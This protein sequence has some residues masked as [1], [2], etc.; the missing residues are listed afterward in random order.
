MSIQ[1]TLIPIINPIRSDLVEVQSIVK[2]LLNS[3][4]KSPVSKMGAHLSQSPG[5]NIRAIITLLSYHI[6]CDRLT[7]TNSPAIEKGIKIAASIEHIHLASLVHDDIIDGSDLRRGIPT[8]TTAFGENQAIIM[9]VYIYALS[10]S[11]LSEVG[12]MDILQKISSTVQTLCAGESK[13]ISNRHQVPE[14]TEEYLRIVYEK[15]GVLFQTACY[16]GARLVTTDN[17]ILTDLEILGAEFGLIF[18]LTDDYLDIFGDGAELNKKA[19]QDLLSGDITLPLLFFL[20]TL[21]PNQREKVLYD[22]REGRTSSIDPSLLKENITIVKDQT[23]EIIRQSLEKIQTVLSKFP[24]SDY[25]DSFL[26]LTETISNRCLS[27][28]PTP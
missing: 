26:L 28:V 14:T 11:L 6:T 23:Q 27:T 21:N 9:G 15:T 7:I 10:L 12:N 16:A 5:K 18:Q 19:G 2:T 13:Q 25:L 17:E 8:I 24:N 20:K 22:I 1:K 4:Q 3:D